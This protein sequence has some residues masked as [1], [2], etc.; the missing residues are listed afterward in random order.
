MQ[1]EVNITEVVA[2]E[3]GAFEIEMVAENLGFV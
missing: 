3:P 2:L 1:T